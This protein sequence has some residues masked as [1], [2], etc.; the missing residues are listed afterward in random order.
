MEARG[1]SI[2]ALSLLAKAQCL[3]VAV[4]QPVVQQPAG[5][6]I[7]VTAVDGEAL[8]FPEGYAEGSSQLLLSAAFLTA[9]LAL[10]Q[11]SLAMNIREPMV[12]CLVHQLH[13]LCPLARQTLLCLSALRIVLRV[14]ALLRL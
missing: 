5:K 2:V 9:E 4:P 3:L 12:S 8:E 11:E 1:P 7:K 10:L 14:W 6:T 13:V